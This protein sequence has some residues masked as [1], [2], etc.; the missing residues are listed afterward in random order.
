MI[1]IGLLT[2]KLA[3]ELSQFLEYKIKIILAEKTMYACILYILLILLSIYYIKIV[4][5]FVHIHST[6]NYRTEAERV[7]F[8]DTKG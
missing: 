3:D 8:Y 7:N 4:D 6:T 2:Q 1:N 5:F